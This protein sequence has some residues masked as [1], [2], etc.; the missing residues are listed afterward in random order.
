MK[1]FISNQSTNL[2]KP[3]VVYSDGVLKGSIQMAIVMKLM[4][5][6]NDCMWRSFEGFYT[7]GYSNEANGP[8]KSFVWSIGNI[9]IG[10][11]SHLKGL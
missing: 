10:L 11:Y 3:Y 6:T 9:T 8:Y 1:G 5:H 7:N 2:Y 4:D